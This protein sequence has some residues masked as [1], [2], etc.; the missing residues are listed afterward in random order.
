MALGG[1]RQRSLLATLLVL[2][3]EVVSSDRLVDEL[4]GEAPPQTAATSLHT[5]VSHLRKALD[6]DRVPG[7]ASAVLVTQAPGYLVRVDRTT[8]DAA[9]FEDLLAQGRG[10]L[11]AGD[12]ARAAATLRDALGLWRGR[13]LDGA[14]STPSARAEAMRLEE[15]RLEALEAR[16]DA[17]LALGRD[18]ELVP[19]LEVLVAREPLRERMQGQL[20]LALY[21]CGRQADALEH[22]QRARDAFR[23]RLGIEPSPRLRELEQAMLRQDPELDEGLPRVRPR[24]V[25][26]R[27]RRTLI[28]ATGVVIAALAALVGV[29]VA[30][31][32]EAPLR[33]TPGSVAVVDPGAGRVVDTIEVGSGP[34]AIVFGHDAVWVANAED[35]TVM[36]IDPESREVVKV[37]GV[38]SPVD[39][40]VGADAIWVAGGID[41]TVTRIDPTS[42]DVVATFDLRGP[43]P[44]VPRTVNAVAAAPG[45]VWAAAAGTELVRIDPRRNRVVAE[46]NLGATPLG[47]AVHSGAVWVVIGSGRL[48]RIQPTTG[49]VASELAVGSPGTFPRGVTAAD[50]GVLVLVD[51]VWVVNPQVTQLERT[52][53][54]GSY[55]T[56]VV[57]QRGAG[58][59]AV[60]YDGTLV[61][62]SG[63]ALAESVRIQVGVGASAVGY[64]AGA[65]WVAIGPAEY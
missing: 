44:F 61:R 2:G 34:A 48:V 57:D 36:R 11:D 65:V 30:T 64:G 46:T 50:D 40:A 38:P 54:V 3:N 14:D 41:G 18:E 55:T 20:M 21:R 49:V 43:D 10:A 17:D 37:I 4:W 59:W 13:A 22:Y 12:A 5:L 56:A 28:V 9:R 31:R 32:P 8:L 39:L 62:F 58:L 7:A 51:D 19:E 53:S 6:P 52:L 27:R 23:D 25:L 16:I 47:V 24:R 35:D 33:A 15:L 29:V 63:P 42:N 26:R 60:T 1:A 45:A